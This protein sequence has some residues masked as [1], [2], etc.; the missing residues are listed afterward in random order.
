LGQKVCLDQLL[1]ECARLPV[2]TAKPLRGE[3]GE[4]VGLEEVHFS[5]FERLA[6]VTREL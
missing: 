2:R 6:R 3:S 1:P 5:T 4:L